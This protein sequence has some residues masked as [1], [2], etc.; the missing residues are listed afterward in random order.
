MMPNRETRLCND[1]IIS[2]RSGFSR[3]GIYVSGSADF[4]RR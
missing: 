2:I 3:L 4:G 1:E